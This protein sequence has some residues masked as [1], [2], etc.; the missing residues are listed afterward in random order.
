MFFGNEV[1]CAWWDNV[2]LN[3]GF[4]SYLEYVI[5]DKVKKQAANYQHKSD[6]I[7]NQF[8][9]CHRSSLTGEF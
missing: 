9:N 6:L 4:A 1:T 3:E 5:A 8:G 2:W 7:K